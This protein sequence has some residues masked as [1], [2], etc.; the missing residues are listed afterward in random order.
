MKRVFRIFTLILFSILS[1]SLNA[2]I[3]TSIA[4]GGWTEASTWDHGTKFPSKN[5]HAIIYLGHTVSLTE[6]ALIDMKSV[7]Q[8]KRVDTERAHS[9][10][11]YSFKTI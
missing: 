8:G 6:N 3:F 2:A 4:T 5:D 9:V 1:L 7:V 10:V 11:K